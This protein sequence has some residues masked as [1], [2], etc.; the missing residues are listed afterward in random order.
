MKCQT[1]WIKVRHFGSRSVD[2]MSDILDQG[3]TFWVQVSRWNVRHFG[4]K[5]RH[6]GSWS[7]DGMSDNLNQGQ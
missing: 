2:G 6:F 3:Q 5:I 4:L 1:F 7:V